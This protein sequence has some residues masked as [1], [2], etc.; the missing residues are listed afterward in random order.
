MKGSLKWLLVWELWECLF[1][2]RGW[3]EEPPIAWVQFK[4]HV[5]RSHPLHDLQQI[6]P[7]T[8]YHRHM[9]SSGLTCQPLGSVESA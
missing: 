5:Q 6:P 7:T 3:G 4:G 9:S 8:R 1:Q 2:G